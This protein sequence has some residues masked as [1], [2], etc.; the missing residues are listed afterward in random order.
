MSQGSVL[1]LS[2]P[3]V[4]G[5]DD[6]HRVLAILETAGWVEAVSGFALAVVLVAAFLPAL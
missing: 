5:R 3:P 6:L 4:I 1:T 2:P